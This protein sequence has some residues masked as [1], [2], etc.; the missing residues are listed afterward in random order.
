MGLLSEI[1][2]IGSFSVAVASLV[3]AIEPDMSRRVKKLTAR[4]LDLAPSGS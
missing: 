4:A 1:A 3:T 2:P